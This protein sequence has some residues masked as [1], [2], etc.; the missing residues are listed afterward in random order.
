MVANATPQTFVDLVRVMDDAMDAGAPMLPDGEPP[1]LSS[2]PVEPQGSRRLSH[3]SR[4]SSDGAHGD[5]LEILKQIQARC[6]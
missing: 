2:A 6:T 5:F 4:L 3:V 1:S